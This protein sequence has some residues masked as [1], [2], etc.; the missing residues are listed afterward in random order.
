MHRMNPEYFEADPVDRSLSADVSLR[1]E[2][3]EDEDEEEDSNNDESD[4]EYE[5]YSE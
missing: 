3:D 1:E 5:G 2:P 4:D